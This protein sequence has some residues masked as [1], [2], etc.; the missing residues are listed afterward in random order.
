M[1]LT[2]LA[3]A[4]VISSTAYAQTVTDEVDRF[5]GQRKIEYTN[6]QDKPAFGKPIPGFFIYQGGSTPNS[7]GR[8][9]ISPVPG[10]YAV[11]SPQFVGCR[12]VDWLVDG[13]PTKLGMVVHDLKRFDRVLVEFLTQEASIEQLATIGSARH[14][15]FRICGKEGELSREDIDAAREIAARAMRTEPHTE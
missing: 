3:L 1:K 5:T 13:A 14:V 12:S 4:L 7:G 11:Q 6:R 9:M 10:R 8:F 2:S 15:E